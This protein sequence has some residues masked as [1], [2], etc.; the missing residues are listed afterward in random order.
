MIKFLVKLLIK[1]CTWRKQVHYIMGN[2]NQDVFLVR[3]IVFKSKTFSIYIHRFL[4]SDA[5][6]PHD[7]PWDFYTYVVENGY[8]E[9]F[10]DL[11]KTIIKDNEFKSY[12]SF[13][14]NLR[15]EGSLA[16]RKATGVHRVVLPRTY[17]LSKIEQAPLT[18]CLMLKR[19]RNW[20]YWKNGCYFID[21]RE[22]LD[23]KPDDPRIAGSE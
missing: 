14:I 7:H 8:Q 12:W 21:W 22:Y 18:I 3:Y 10:Y 9:Y 15:K 23:I 5:D 17:T 6:D 11:S 2:N 13:D 16:F 1:Y 4:H 20:G 19:Q